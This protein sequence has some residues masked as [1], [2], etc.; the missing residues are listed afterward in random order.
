MHNCRMH[1]VLIYCS[2]KFWLEVIWLKV[3]M[4]HIESMFLSFWLRIFQFAGS[5]TLLCSC[6][7]WEDIHTSNLHFCSLLATM[8]V[9]ISLSKQTADYSLFKIS[10][11]RCSPYL[12]V[13]KICPIWYISKYIFKEVSGH[14][15]KISWRDW[16]KSG[17]FLLQTNKVSIDSIHET[18]I[19]NWL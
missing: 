16:V 18:L 19:L 15:F 10:F 8:F 2:P 5:K 7:R 3:C 11:R 6:W 12:F 17:N 14:S 1:F 13:I 4:F 9:Y